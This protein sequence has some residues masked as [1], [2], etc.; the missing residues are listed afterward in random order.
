MGGDEEACRHAQA[1][2]NGV[3]AF[4]AVRTTATL[5]VIGRRYCW[6]G[7]LY[8]DSHGEEDRGLTRGRPLLLA[9]HRL[10]ELTSL[11]QGN[12]LREFLHNNP[13]PFPHLLL[14]RQRRG[15]VE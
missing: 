5:L 1:A 3:C 10:A 9:P 4:I 8:L 13:P 6:W 11:W 2:H 7:S 14:L 12:G 15:V